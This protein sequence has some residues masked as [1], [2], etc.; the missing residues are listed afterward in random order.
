M[1]NQKTMDQ[2]FDLCQRMARATAEHKYQLQNLEQFLVKSTT[3]TIAKLVYPQ[4]QSRLAV[5]EA[6]L[7][8]ICNEAN[9]YAKAE[10]PGVVQVVWRSIVNK[11]NF[12]LRSSAHMEEVNRQ[13]V[14]R[15]FGE[16]EEL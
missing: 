14:L 8:D 9:E 7:K 2:L 4:L 15:E 1:R 10:P 11:A 13:D 16:K 12:A 5:L 3:N 6:A